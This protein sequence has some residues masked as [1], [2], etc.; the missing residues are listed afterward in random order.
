MKISRKG[1][2]IVKE[3]KETRE[4]DEEDVEEEQKEGEKQEGVRD[5]GMFTFTES[6]T[7]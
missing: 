5:L 2:E 1:E 6:E 4:E 7:I 3:D